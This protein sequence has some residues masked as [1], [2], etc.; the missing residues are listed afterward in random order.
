MLDELKYEEAR[1][2][3]L[4]DIYLMTPRQMAEKSKY[5]FNSYNSL[6]KVVDEMELES[7]RNPL[8]KMLK[9]KEPFLL[10]FY[11][12]NPV[13][14]QE[15]Y[16]TLKEKGYINSKLKVE[17]FMPFNNNQPIWSASGS[18]YFGHHA[19]PGGLVLHTEENLKMSLGIA[20]AHSEIFNLKFNTDMVVFAQM[21]HDLSKT[22]LLE[23][24]EDASC[25]SQ[26]NIAQT[27]AHHIFGL[28]ESICHHLEPKTLFAQ[29]CTHLNPGNQKACQII[30]DFLRAAF[31]IADIDPVDYGL[32]DE[33][34]KLTFDY[35]QMEFWFC[36]VGDHSVVFTVPSFKTVLKNLEILAQE[37]YNFHKEE[38]HTSKFNKFRNYVLAQN[39][40]TILYKMLSEGDKKAF[41]KQV[42]KLFK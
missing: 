41:K 3:K 33:E 16:D 11:K 17:D 8:N 1:A 9:E 40:I 29:A 35:K 39:T 37:E 23:W 32:F 7:L 19:H 20:R 38:L 31:I 30:C 36:Y 14:R 4:S 34:D 2:E 25:M 12:S 6:L 15:V 24:Q 10:N 26:Y 18:H 22:W 27:G 13:K 28:A 5:V 21:A 42:A